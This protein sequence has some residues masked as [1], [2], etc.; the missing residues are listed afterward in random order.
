VL[1]FIHSQM[2]RFLAVEYTDLDDVLDDA[3]DIILSQKAS[4]ALAV[5]SSLNN[6]EESQTSSDSRS[7]L[8]SRPPWRVAERLRFEKA[9][10]TMTKSALQVNRISISLA[11]GNDH[12]RRRGSHNTPSAPRL[13]GEIRD[14]GDG[15]EV[16]EGGDRESKRESENE[17]VCDFTEA[18]AD[19]M[20]IDVFTKKYFKDISSTPGVMTAPISFQN[21]G[22]SIG[23]VL[24]EERRRS[25]SN[26]LTTSAYGPR[27]EATARL[28]QSERPTDATART[29]RPID[30]STQEA[31]QFEYHVQSTDAVVTPLGI[32]Q[33]LPANPLHLSSEAINSSSNSNSNS[34]SSSNSENSSSTTSGN[35][36]SISS[37]PSS[38]EGSHPRVRR[39]QSLDSFPRLQR[40]YADN[41]STPSN[42]SLRRSSV[43][44]RD[45]SAAFSSY[46][47]NGNSTRSSTSSSSGS[48][49]RSSFANSSVLSPVALEKMRPLRKAAS[50]LTGRRGTFSGKHPDAVVAAEAKWNDLAA[51]VGRRGV[52]PTSA[53]LLRFSS[54]QFTCS[55]FLFEPQ[56]LRLHE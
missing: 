56:R 7:E 53:C 36:A 1:P 39:R 34:S 27:A 21:A 40:L 29:E 28:V 12:S 31:N 46:N 32:I 9:V 33:A 30:M 23:S 13:W 48:G 47:G 41:F 44:S 37:S 45:C 35:S 11:F 42:S 25:S 5:S 16:G 15:D 19:S 55:S 2:E 4:D 49:R 3:D 54:S 52:L 50:K 51:V 10:Q 18:L 17:E 6:V 20:A 8:L 38:H 22:S 24:S 43:D 26:L 14:S